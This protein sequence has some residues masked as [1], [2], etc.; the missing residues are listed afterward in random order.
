MRQYSYRLILDSDIGV[1]SDNLSHAV[2]LETRTNVR[3]SFRSL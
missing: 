3:E 1:N 2:G